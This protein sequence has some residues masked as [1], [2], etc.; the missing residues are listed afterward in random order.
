MAKPRRKVPRQQLIHHEPLAEPYAEYCTTVLTSGRQCWSAAHQS[1]APLRHNHH[2]LPEAKKSERT[3]SRCE[4]RKGVTF[5]QRGHR[6][7]ARHLTSNDVEVSDILQ[8][9]RQTVLPVSKKHF[10]HVGAWSWR[11]SAPA[12]NVVLADLAYRWTRQIWGGAGICS[13]PDE[14]LTMVT[15]TWGN[16]ETKQPAYTR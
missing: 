8:L 1:I 3:G 15:G 4:A 11:L 16:G 9:S 12:R 2:R 6:D 13:I 7:R 14:M 5:D 10:G